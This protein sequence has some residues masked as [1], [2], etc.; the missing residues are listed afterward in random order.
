MHFQT[1][2]QNSTQTNACFDKSVI[3]LN[4]VDELLQGESQMGNNNRQQ[5]SSK[6]LIKTSP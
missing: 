5:I 6:L 1:F 2:L 3:N 4:Q